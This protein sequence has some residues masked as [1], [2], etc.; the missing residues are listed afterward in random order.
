MLRTD[1]TNCDE[2]TAYAFEKAGGSSQLVHVNS[3]RSGRDSFLNYDILAIP[4]GFSYGDDIAAGAVLANELIS[5]LRDQLVCFV[6]RG[7]LVLGICNGFQVLVRTGLLPFQNIGRQS[8][9]LTTNDVG[10][11]ECRWVQLEFAHESQ[12]VFATGLTGKVLHLP[13]AHGEGKFI[14][15]EGT[16]QAV[17]EQRLAPLRYHSYGHP[18]LQYPA[19]PNGSLDGM[20]K[21]RSIA[22][23]FNIPFA[24]L[25][26]GLVESA[27]Q[28]LSQPFTYCQ[29]MLRS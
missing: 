6:D 1:G 2:E 13:I 5:F 12:C 22:S 26:W 24:Y 3:L 18:T 17:H 20:H 14:T 9:S 23:L 11:F 7:R 27:M 16:L 21:R 28:L 8:V 19:N 15:E 10:K 4:G 29:R 25:V